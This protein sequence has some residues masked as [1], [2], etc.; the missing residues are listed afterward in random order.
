M[1]DRSPGATI[2]SSVATGDQA[3]VLPIHVNADSSAGAMRLMD[4]IEARTLTI[5]GSNPANDVSKTGVVFILKAVAEKVSLRNESF[6]SYV[7]I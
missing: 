7:T 6:S 4:C 1:Y 5:D 3:I 2:N